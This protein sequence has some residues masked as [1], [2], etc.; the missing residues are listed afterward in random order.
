MKYLNSKKKDKY[1]IATE[2]KDNCCTVINTQERAN[3]ALGSE[4]NWSSQSWGSLN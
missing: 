2:N 3:H 1:F 4:A